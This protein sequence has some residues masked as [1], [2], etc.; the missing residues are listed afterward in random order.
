MV[1]VWLYK[2]FICCC[3]FEVVL[4]LD[5]GKIGIMIEI[6]VVDIF[7]E[8]IVDDIVQVIVVYWLLLGIKLWEEV[9]V[10]VYYVS[11][12][13]I[14]VVLLMFVKDKLICMELDCGVFVVKFD[15]I[16]VC[17]VFVVCCVLEVVLV[18]E[19]IVKVMLVDYKWLEKYLVEEYKVVVSGDLFDVLCCNCL[20]VD[21]YFLMVDV[22]GN[23]VFKEMLYEFFVCSLVIMMMYQLMYDVVCLFDEYIV[24]LDVVKCGD[25]EGVIVLMEE[26]MVYIEVLFKFELL[27]GCVMDFV[28]VFLV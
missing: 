1:M 22:V 28:V 20:M 4:L 17:E 26:Y 11:C 15:E 25:V 3:M 13:K 27:G 10:W 16:E 12:M 6:I 8:G 5:G 23:S 21:F 14:C 24:F 19:F 9:L 2:L 18:C 7:F